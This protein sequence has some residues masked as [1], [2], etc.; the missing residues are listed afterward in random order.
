LVSAIDCSNSFPVFEVSASTS[1]F[2]SPER[3]RIVRV[4]ARSVRPID[5]ERSRT[6]R[7]CS[8]TNFA[9]L[10]PSRASALTPSEASPE[11]VG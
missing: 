9:S 2:A 8:L 1:D 3:R 6:R 5:R 11:S 7:F 4:I 10:R